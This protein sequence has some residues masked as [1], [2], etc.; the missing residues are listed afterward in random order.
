MNPGGGNLKI[1]DDL[2]KASAEAAQLKAH[3]AAA[4]NMKTGTIDFTK[5][6]KSIKDSGS[7]LA[8]YGRTLRSMGPEGQKAF[9]QFAQAVAQSEI[10][11]RKT[12]KLVKEMGTTL[13]NSLR[14]QLS[15]SILHGF[16]TSMQD[17]YN[18]AKNLNSSLTDIR[19]VSGQ[20]ADQ[21]A[22]F[23]KQANIAAK[24][25]STTTNEYAKAALIYYQQGLKQQEVLERTEVTVKMANVTGDAEQEVSSYMTAIWNNFNKAGDESV[26]HFADIM[27]KLGA[28]T[29]A[30]TSEIAAGLSKFSAVA[31]TIGLSFEMATSAVTAIVDQT[32]ETPEVVGTAL[33]TIFSRIEGLQQG[34]TMEDGVN[35]NKYS[36][37]LQKVGVDIMDTN[38][39][40][41]D[42][43][44]ILKEIG[45]KWETLDKNQQVALAQT[46]AGIRQYN[47]FMALFDNWD[48]VEQN[49]TLAA[50]AE[51]TLD[52]QADIYAESW[53]AASKRARASM[54]GLFDS[55]LEDD[56][57]IGLLNGFSEVIGF[58]EGVVDALGGMKGLLLTIGAILTNVF[59]KQMASGIRN[60]ADNIKMMTPKGREAIAN[61]KR[62]QVEEAANARFD[63]RAGYGDR[64][65]KARSDSLKEQIGLQQQL[66]ENEEKMNAI[67]KDTAKILM[68][69]HQAL[70]EESADK[71]K[72]ADQ[73][74]S[75]QD[76][77][78]DRI[79]YAQVDTF[80]NQYGEVDK[81]ALVGEW[82][83]IDKSFNKINTETKSWLQIQDVFKEIQSGSDLTSEHLDKLNKATQN[84]D[85]SGYQ[86]LGNLMPTLTDSADEAK[87]KL[88]SMVETAEQL[89]NSRTQK[90][91]L[92]Y[93]IDTDD[94]INE[95]RDSSRER[96]RKEINSEDA[97][98]R[99]EKS[100]QQAQETMKSSRGVQAS[101]ADGFISIANAAANAMMVVTMLS[102][103]IATLKN[104]DASGWDK[105]LA[106]IGALGVA[107]PVLTSSYTML[108][109]A[110]SVAGVS[111]LADVV[112]SKASA[113][114]KKD[115]SVK[116]MAAAAAEKAKAAAT[117][118]STAATVADAV[119]DGVNAAATTAETEAI[120]A[121]TGATDGNTASNLTNA[122][123][124]YKQAFAKMGSALTNMIAAHP[125]I[126]AGVL[127]AAA[128]I[129][130][131][132]KAWN[133]D[134]EA[135]EKAAKAAA[136][137]Q[138]AYEDAASAHDDVKTS[139]DNYNQATDSIAN[140]TK[141]TLE[142]TEAV[143][144]CNQEV[145]SLLQKFPDLA[146][147]ITNVNGKMEI[148]SAGLAYIQEQS[149]LE[150]N[151][152]Y[153]TAL[154]ASS[155]AK[156]AQF[157]SDKTNFLRSSP[158]YANWDTGMGGNISRN[159]LNEILDKTQEIGTGFLHSPEQISEVLGVGK[160]LA[161][162]I[163]E[164]S[165]EII[166]LSNQ[167]SINSA[168]N[169]VLAEQ[170]GRD[171]LKNIEGYEDLSS[172]AQT[173]IAKKYGEEFIKKSNEYY[174]KKYSNWA[175]KEVQ[176][177]YAEMIGAEA[178]KNK[179]D[180][181]GEYLID[182]E[183]KSVADETARMALA[184][185]DASVA[186]A[187]LGN[188]ATDAAKALAGLADA[189]IDD[190]NLGLSDEEASALENYLTSGDISG[191]ENLSPESIEKIQGLVDEGKIDIENYGKDWED[192][193][194]I[195]AKDFGNEITSDLAEIKANNL[196]KEKSAETDFTNA[197]MLEMARN[198]GQI[199]EATAS[200]A[201]GQV[202]IN[203]RP[204]PGG[205]V[206][207]AEN[208]YDYGEYGVIP[209]SGEY[210]ILPKDI[211][212][213][214]DQQELLSQI[215]QMAEQNGLSKDQIDMAKVADVLAEYGLDKE[216]YK[217]D[218]TALQ[219]P[220]SNTY[221]AFEEI[222]QDLGVTSRE[223]QINAEIIN[224]KFDSAEIEEYA[225]HLQEVAE[226]S[227]EI[228]D[229]VADD[230]LGA[231]D[232][233]IDLKKADKMMTSLN[234]T[235]EEYG[236]I[237]KDS[238]KKGTTEYLKGMKEIKS[239]LADYMDV[240]EEAFS[241]EKIAEA[242]DL[243]AFEGN[244][245]ALEDLL[246]SGFTEEQIELNP[247]I[248]P[249]KFQE[250]GNALDLLTDMAPDIDCV[251]DVDAEPALAGLGSI[252]DMSASTQAALDALGYE[253]VVE[254]A[255][256]EVE[257]SEENSMVQ[258]TWTDGGEVEFPARVTGPLME[259]ETGSIFVSSPN[260]NMTV[261]TNGSTPKKKK[262]QM[263]GWDNA[264]SAAA[265]GQKVKL[266]RT[267][268]PTGS[269]GGRKG[270]SGGGGGGGGGKT[271]KIKKSPR[272][273]KQKRYEQVTNKLQDLARAQKNAADEADRL[274]GEDRLKKMD[275]VST[276]IKEQ[277]KLL[278]ETKM[279]EAEAYKQQDQDDLIKY[280]EFLQGIYG[281][282]PNAGGI[283]SLIFDEEGNVSNIEDAINF[284]GNKIQ[285]IEDSYANEA[286]ISESDEELKTLLEERK[287][288]LESYYEAYKESDEVLEEIEDENEAFERELQDIAFENINYKLEF[289]IELNEAELEKINYFFNKTQ[290]DNI[291]D[292]AEGLMIYGNRWEQLA[293]SA[294]HYRNTYNEL[295]KSFENGEISKDQLIKGQKEAIS[296]LIEN[297]EQMQEFLEYTTH[298]YYA[299]TLEMG[300]EEIDKYAE[301]FD[302][303]SDA[304]DHYMNIA[305]TLGKE[306]DYKYMEKFLN[307]NIS[308]I[309]N[310]LAASTDK[311]NMLLEQRN[312]W[313]E[314]LGK[315]EYG[316]TEYE[317]VKKNLE[318][319]NE[320]V[321]EAYDERLSIVE[322]KAEAIRALIENK[323]AQAAKSFEDALTDGSGFDSFMSQFEKLNSRQEEYLTKTNQIYETNKL[324]RQAAQAA[325][326]TDNE[327]AKRKFK[328]FENETKKL[329]ET[330]KLSNYELE[331]Q[332]AKYD[333]LLAEIA[334]EEAQNAKSTVRLQRD[335]E[336]NFGYVYTANKDEI[337]DAQQ[338]YED[339]Q[340]ALYN[341]SL[342][343]QQDYTA[344]YLE[345][346]QMMQE[347]LAELD[348]KWLNGE[349]DTIEEYNR[350]RDA[351]TDHYFNPDT[352][353]L[354]TYS[355]LYNIAVQTDANATED[356]W[357]KS[358]GNMTIRTEEWKT[359]VN[360]Y[361]AEIDTAF[362]LWV[363]SQ[364]EL[365]ND[366][367]GTLEDN[368]KFTEDVKTKSAAL[369]ETIT[370]SVIP[371]VQQE[372]KE[373]EELTQKW[374]D[375]ITTMES[376]IKENEKII[377][378]EKFKSWRDYGENF[379]FLREAI[380]QSQG[381]GTTDLSIDEALD[382][383]KQKILDSPDL[384]KQL[385]YSGTKEEVA[386]QID[387][388]HAGV[389]N[390]L[391]R[392]NAS[393]GW[394]SYT[395]DYLHSIAGSD[396]KV[397]SLDEILR[398]YTD[399]S[400]DMLMLSGDE[401]YKKYAAYSS[402]EEAAKARRQKVSSPWQAYSLEILFERA[403]HESK[404]A[405]YLEDLRTTFDADNSKYPEI[406]PEESGI[407]QDIGN[408]IK[409]YASGDT[410]G[411][412]KN[413]SDMKE[414]LE[415]RKA[416]ADHFN[417]LPEDERA[418]TIGTDD[419]MKEIYKKFGVSFDT[420][421]YTGSWG[422]QG[423]LAMLHQKELILNASDTEN[424]LKMIEIVRDLSQQIDIFA[425]RQS[426]QNSLLSNPGYFS[427]T[428]GTLEQSVHIE[429]SF[430]GVTDR[431]QIEEAFGNL[432]NI[433]YQH[434]NRR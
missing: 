273:S 322:E 381:M 111:A 420:G 399:Y 254:V 215:Y 98:K 225:K 321:E 360:G 85:Y 62:K 259:G 392:G 395:Q 148:T 25:L 97:E 68:D 416:V 307:A 304:V 297:A 241:E 291:Y 67:E 332:Q 377:D 376:A 223:E 229:I 369:A 265:S 166:E 105:F 206:T 412:I 144:K 120:I 153:H 199:V 203:G 158:I 394:S 187:E 411:Y 154:V 330:T 39:K 181:T 282:N 159:V 344:K 275:E 388:D 51:G 1:T 296:S 177:K 400:F 149:Q 123:S 173:S 427:P 350:Q 316:S 317:Q 188:S 260:A 163:Y 234:E 363:T 87:M 95:V 172:N 355:K 231:K 147:E 156:E 89:S 256:A 76:N 15:S 4:T 217:F 334:L 230:F 401:K 183:W 354:S 99:R 47:Q 281:S 384:W 258:T 59:G 245:E 422:P 244:V 20:S 236:D 361:I 137:A 340:N 286:I 31:D 16:M 90:E 141:G 117:K 119:A 73:A 6:N 312:Y 264:K 302:R 294:E 288:L 91:L 45:N 359:A 370:T 86:A 116:T 72:E 301:G 352:G 30:S 319:T 185:A 5:L 200:E 171:N 271:S 419:E 431:N 40:L 204:V 285:A 43:D 155:N 106:I 306:T 233:A 238:S 136:E 249:E 414:A 139:I 346:L 417:N 133:A 323:M 184:E 362:D 433:A 143:N 391:T 198:N 226:T 78:K 100:Y 373:V 94:A 80:T 252:A 77:I 140:L 103:A 274:Y 107:I 404:L 364:T 88:Q 387:E 142:W 257:D 356:Y 418:F 410:S 108:A 12:N 375:Y 405:K 336:G 209:S 284:L 42:A 221:K 386:A 52:Q 115:L 61:E 210:S 26:E 374:I 69:Q 415:S 232:L 37:G 310:K 112:A 425:A 186:V 338:K 194:F 329:Q 343:G 283:A 242:I 63:D 426:L 432:V 378:P 150:L 270:G 165:S 292:M 195:N 109:S 262:Y 293:D 289:E 320:A 138:K 157:E 197:L 268:L 48:K 208:P 220:E 379:D 38:G 179:A 366:L 190:E 408:A 255:D 66:Y 102:G 122:A 331:I 164:N 263:I 110:E 278:K 121:N 205:V 224:E 11:L 311:Y 365:N 261:N 397:Y 328:N 398:D 175:D 93:G 227:E 174:D 18:Y 305:S 337:A 58:I 33:K 84:F 212:P 315:Y 24:D 228:S 385:G 131:G 290:K 14:W 371:A 132:V 17:A 279:V 243:G 269:G 54:E 2:R 23:A 313:E 295:Q 351:I 129:W 135:A 413:D 13:K 248:S 168:T 428:N 267:H 235:M 193:D 3:L 368:A 125:L 71:A 393:T 9:T 182:G 128:A 79:K 237:L 253:P 160:G 104:P 207:T 299:E 327:V 189:L 380:R 28:A 246:I 22:R 403:K 10:P 358:Y 240:S 389:K 276:K 335:N 390:S 216:D 429:A 170:I 326:K 196:E 180:G 402:Y 250:I 27:T 202:T 309:N 213:T 266:Q 222:G 127:A 35:L 176:D 151:R 161:E 21:M 421:G 308:N 211:K 167:M 396:S 46:T 219:D 44:Q 409:A 287:S 298:E 218:E 113:A 34:E 57:F 169:E 29:A 318:A 201:P 367:N 324:M 333:L 81:K 60:M 55:I 32:R 192:T 407:A 280:V 130:I 406:K 339:A 191:L 92:K 357:G 126:T 101:A 349:I 178:T 345:S 96:T 214:A 341:I 114:A 348:E 50:T 65:G 434:A 145:L 347:E 83:N 19:I 342:Q 424:M 82:S 8:D 41:K 152:A 36:K 251:V 53:E 7:S 382:L 239:S 64:E 74:K 146:G 134:A 272:S 423:K 75:V 372:I 430:P 383:R 314:Q 70:S 162:A 56:F 300:I 247:T 303:L 124:E 325:D 353:V 118:Q 277:I 49:L